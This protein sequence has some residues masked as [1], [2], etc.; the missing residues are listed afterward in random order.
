MSGMVFVV[1]APSGTGK[2]SLVDAV[3][4]GD[5]QLAV[6]VSHTT[7]PPRAGERDGENY[8]FVSEETFQSLI[9]QKKFIEYA[10]VFN[11]WYGTSISSIKNLLAAEKEVILEIDWQGFDIVRKQFETV[12]IF[13]LPPSK[14]TLVER[15]THRAKDKP[16]IIEARIKAADTEVK[17]Y[18]LYDY[19][20]VNDNFQQT[21]QDMQAIFRAARLKQRQQAPKLKDLLAQF[22]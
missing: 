20:L 18:N 5:P 11:N 3:L 2:T 8:H 21:V 13:I 1:S 12:S 14:E 16:E 19:L 6:S 22:G 17:H 10:K 7:R 9:E 4:S 15:L